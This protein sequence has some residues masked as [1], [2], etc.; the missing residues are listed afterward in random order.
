LANRQ[1]CKDQKIYL[2]FGKEFWKVGASR[3]MRYIHGCRLSFISYI[4][5][6]FIIN[7]LRRW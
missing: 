7:I 1:Y 5:V 4:S 6:L 3:S 2:G